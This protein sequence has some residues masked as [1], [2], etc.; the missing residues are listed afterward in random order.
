M[1]TKIKF[2]EVYDQTGIPWEVA[3]H[4]I[5]IGKL[6]TAMNHGVRVI[7][8]NDKWLRFLKVFSELERVGVFA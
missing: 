5:G 8:K 7:V 4:W 1:K 6:D 2:S 3:K